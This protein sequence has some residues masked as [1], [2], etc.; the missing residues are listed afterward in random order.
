MRGITRGLCV[1]LVLQALLSCSPSPPVPKP[2]PAQRGRD[3]W[4]QSTYGGQKF[5]AFLAHH[6]DPG[7][8]VEIGFKNVINT[9]RDQRFQTW[10]TIN[11]PDCRADPAGGPDLCPDPN[12]TGVIGIRK[13]HVGNAT[14]YG[15]ACASCHAGFD[16]LHPPIDVNEPTWDNIHPTIGNQYLKAGRIFA[17]NLPATDPRRIMLEAWPDGTVDTTLLFNDHIMNPGVITAFWD[18]PSRP[19]F[20]VG[21]DEPKMRAGQ[22]GED[23]VGGDLAAIRVY[24]NLGVC[25]LECVAERPDRPDPRA[26]ID[27]AQCRRRCADLPPK[28]DIEDLRVFLQS[29]RPPKLP[30]EGL[31]SQL[32][33]RGREVF[34]RACT[35]CHTLEGKAARVLSNDEVNPIAA[36]LVNAT[37]HCRALTTNWEAER[38]WAG[39]SSSVYKDRAASHRKGYRTMPLAGIWATAPFLHNQSIGPYPSP[40]APPMERAD[41]YE[42]AMR[43]LLSTF[44]TPKMLV[45]PSPLGPFPAGT[46]LTYVFSRDPNTGAIL[47]HDGVE[48]HGHYYGAELARADKEALIH[49][50]KYQ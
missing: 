14:L 11:D 27:V 26:P 38:I 8:R 45:L 24:M 34:R 15:L 37:N 16:P 42:A 41:A 28:R 13:F 22:G 40:T 20:E 33:V 7:V 36:D 18:L 9:P 4:F 47:C 30:R 43:E 46:P 17:A 35:S 3:I 50:L 48:N 2:S 29:I 25:F 44:R 5:F 6:P 21:L 39:F 12:A 10:G 31:N 23:D 49:W 19:T 1:L 32:Y